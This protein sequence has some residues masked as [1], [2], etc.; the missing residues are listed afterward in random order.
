MPPRRTP[1]R[2][3]SSAVWMTGRR[4]CSAGRVAKIGRR[5]EAEAASRVGESGEPADF[6]QIQQLIGNSWY[7]CPAAA[8]Q[9]TCKSAQRPRSSVDRAQVSQKGWEGAR[10]G[11]FEGESGH[12]GAFAGLPIRGRACGFPQSSSF[13]ATSCC[14]CLPR[15][16]LSLNRAK[17]NAALWAATNPPRVGPEAR[18]RASPA[19]DSSRSSLAIRWRATGQ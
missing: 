8:G 9:S 15:P 19:R 10:T 16:G 7:S 14:R 12:S 4:T 1:C 13:L 6:L 3:R 18:R 2:V 17:S 11:P 5:G